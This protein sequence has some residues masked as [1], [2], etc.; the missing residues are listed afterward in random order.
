HLGAHI[1]HHHNRIGLVEGDACLAKDL[2][3]NQVLVFGKDSSR[4]DDAEPLSG[5]RNLPINAVAR[6]AGFVADDGAA[7]SY[8]AIE[9]RGLA[10][11]W[12]AYDGQHSG[13]R[14]GG[15]GHLTSGLK[16]FSHEATERHS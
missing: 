2:R 12:A 1:D 10:D 3:R 16:P 7:A 8:E 15:L 4:I 11:V 13:F 5:P 9:E 14:C 6:D